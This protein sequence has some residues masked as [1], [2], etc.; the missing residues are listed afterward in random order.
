MWITISHR[1]LPLQM[2][3]SLPFRESNA[4]T[5]FY[6]GCMA[7]LARM[8]GR[9]RMPVK[10]WSTPAALLPFRGLLKNLSYEA[11]SQGMAGMSAILGYRRLNGAGAR[12]ARRVGSTAAAE[13]AQSVPSK[14]G[15]CTWNW[16]QAQL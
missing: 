11:A 13:A 12:L 9:C 5:A 3:Q 14:P 7:G 10:I 2:R 4:D 8:P 15:C 6:G 1:L 16:R